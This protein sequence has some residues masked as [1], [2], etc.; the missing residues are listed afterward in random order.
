MC[1]LYLNIIICPILMTML[2]EASVYEP[3]TCLSFT[4]DLIS[5]KNTSF[6][7]SLPDIFIKYFLLAVFLLTFVLCFCFPVFSSLSLL[8]LKL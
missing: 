5:L 1:F 7:I 4:L 8:L 3:I 2:Q 6:L